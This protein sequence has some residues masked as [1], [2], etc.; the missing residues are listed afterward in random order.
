MV[1]DYGK[2]R[3]SAKAFMRMCNNVALG[4]TVKIIQKKLQ[5]G[6]GGKTAKVVSVS[7][8]IQGEN[9]TQIE[10]RISHEDYRADR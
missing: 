8:T 5:E 7:M 3:T 9:G 4:E 1:H 2:M 10:T 6:L